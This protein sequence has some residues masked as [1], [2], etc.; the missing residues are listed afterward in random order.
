MAKANKS[1]LP[2]TTSGMILDARR[3]NSELSGVSHKT[4]QKQ[5]SK[6]T[7]A[8]TNISK[9]NAHVSFLNKIAMTRSDPPI[10]DIRDT[11][12]WMVVDYLGGVY[13][14]DNTFTSRFEIA[15]TIGG[16]SLYSYFDATLFYVE[17]GVWITSAM[18]TSLRKHL[19]ISRDHGTTWNPTSLIA[20]DDIRFADATEDGTHYF[21]VT[22]TRLYVSKDS[23]STWT[24]LLTTSGIN[25]S[26]IRFGETIIVI[27]PGVLH[28]SINDGSSWTNVLTT[29][30]ET[31]YAYDIIRLQTSLLFIAWN[32]SDKT[33]RYTSTNGLTWTQT[34]LANGGWRAFQVRGNGQQF[35]VA[36]VQDTVTDIPVKYSTN[37]GATWTSGSGSV[38]GCSIIDNVQYNQFI[39]DCL[40]YDGNVYILLTTY[41]YYT[42]HTSYDG[43]NWTELS[44]PRIEGTISR[45]SPAINDITN[46]RK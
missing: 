13:L 31:I 46:C 35:L 32:G 29:F 16:P 10:I 1:R 21:V 24:E 26:M 2:A 25:T 14:L 33:Y 11:V 22:T 18:S 38:E 8:V 42:Y 39:M 12:Y 36:A 19:Y 6:S 9:N 23:A 4:K 45:I 30:T 27:G 15:A 37:G 17:K 3:S 5:D 7:I 34:T 43:I 41:P 20:P 28:T 44:I 40:R